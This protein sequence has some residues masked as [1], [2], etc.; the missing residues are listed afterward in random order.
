MVIPSRSKYSNNAIVYLRLEPRR[1]RK[2]AAVI[3]PFSVRNLYRTPLTLST[4][5]KG[6]RDPSPREP[7]YRRVR[8]SESLHLTCCESHRAAFRS[9]LNPVGTSAARR[10]S[11]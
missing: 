2:A 11:F 5:L 4:Q 3:S 7:P 1:S 8:A 6:N 10:E 9:L